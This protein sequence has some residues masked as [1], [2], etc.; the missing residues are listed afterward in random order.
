MARPEKIIVS[1][2]LLLFVIAAVLEGLSRLRDRPDL[3]DGARWAAVAALFV[4]LIPIALV[5]VVLGVQAWFARKRSP[6][7]S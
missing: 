1:T 7:G 6:N 3:H 4:V 5:G 2:G